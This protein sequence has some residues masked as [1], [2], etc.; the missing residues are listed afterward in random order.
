MSRLLKILQELDAYAKKFYVLKALVL[1]VTQ[2]KV[3][4]IWYF[5]IVLIKGQV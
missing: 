2:L 1:T 3:F 5:Q 4:N